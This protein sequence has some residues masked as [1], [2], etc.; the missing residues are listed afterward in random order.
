MTE[1][2]VAG[3]SVAAAEIEST[4]PAMNST[5]LPSSHVKSS[6]PM[7][8]VTSLAVPLLRTVNVHVALAKLT[9]DDRIVTHRLLMV[10]DVGMLPGADPS[11]DEL[12]PA[13]SPK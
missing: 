7:V 4:S 6:M 11:S 12:G 3:E 13:T 2:K 8:V 1:G 10:P 9:P 5:R